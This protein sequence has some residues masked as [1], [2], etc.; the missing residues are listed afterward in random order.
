MNKSQ[1][2]YYPSGKEEKVKKWHHV[3]ANE[4]ILGRLAS[5]IASILSGKEKATYTPSVDEGDFVVVTNIKK[6]LL[7]G[8]KREQKKYN[9]HTG[10]PGGI[11]ERSF[12]D[13]LEK[14]PQK[15]LM[16][17]VKGMLPK[18][19]LG[20]QMLTKLKVYPGES[21]PHKAQNPVHLIINGGIDE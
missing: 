9:W 17:A 2:S 5:R 4:Q 13:M 3:D 15:V 8:K 12:V 7:T 20:R 21:H 1:K 18:N 14:Q 11:K 19:S 6:V 16:E 10:Y